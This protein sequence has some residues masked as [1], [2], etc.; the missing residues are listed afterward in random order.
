M[1]TLNQF[2]EE[3]TNQS[4]RMRYMNIVAKIEK[5]LSLNDYDPETVKEMQKVN[6]ICVL[7]IHRIE[8]SND[9]KI[10]AKAFPDDKV[11]SKLSDILTNN[12]DKVIVLADK[13]ITKSTPLLNRKGV[14]I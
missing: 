5:Y 4:K 8:D 1:K 6:N 13:Q 2:L 12:S 3:S 10:K 9:Y 14:Y 11:A 7:A